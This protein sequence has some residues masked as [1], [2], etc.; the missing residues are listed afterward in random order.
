MKSSQ[1][2]ITYNGTLF[3]WSEEKGLHSTRHQVGN[4]F[5][6]DKLWCGEQQVWRSGNNQYLAVASNVGPVSKGNKVNITLELK[7]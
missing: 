1:I 7:F 2:L 4:V 5:Y 3:S 6:K